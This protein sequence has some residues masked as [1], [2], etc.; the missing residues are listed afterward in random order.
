MQ[1]GTAR[2]GRADIVIVEPSHTPNAGEP[3]K[4][5]K[6]KLWTP[7]EPVELY[8][9]HEGLLVRTALLRSSHYES[10]KRAPVIKQ[11]E[12]LATLAEHIGFM[13]QEHVVVFALNQRN[14]VVGIYE[15]AIGPSDHAFLMAK[16]V[17]KV[18]LLT[19]ARAAALVHNHPGGD[20]SPSTEDMTLTKAVSEALA[21]VD[22][23]LLDHVIVSFGRWVSL[24]ELGLWR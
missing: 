4:R 13:D 1:H 2:G 10:D 16:D 9:G 22:L 7:E 8:G 23:H 3:R 19:G 5:R 12:D 21:C 24:L 14:K 18:L 20:P 15:V 17:I 6:K 11:A